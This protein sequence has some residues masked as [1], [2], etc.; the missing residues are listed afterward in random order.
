MKFLSG[1]AKIRFDATKVKIITKSGGVYM[2][3]K[4]NCPKI[5]QVIFC[6]V[7]SHED[8]NN[9]LKA[10]VYDYLGRKLDNFDNENIQ[11]PTKLNLKRTN[12]L[13]EN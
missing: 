11:P 6:Y 9:F 12:N 5:G 1:F 3:R 2:P 7:G 4:S 13:I 10:T 8:Y